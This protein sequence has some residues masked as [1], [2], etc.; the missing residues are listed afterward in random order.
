MLE[1]NT[2]EPSAAEPAAASAAVPVVGVKQP[3]FN[4]SLV[5]PRAEHVASGLLGVADTTVAL[6]HRCIT[7]LYVTQQL[8]IKTPTGCNC[9]IDL[10]QLSPLDTTMTEDV[11]RVD[12]AQ[13]FKDRL[14]EEQEHGQAH[15]HPHDYCRALGAH[16]PRM[17]RGVSMAKDPQTIIGELQDVFHWTWLIRLVIV[18]LTSEPES[19]TNPMHIID[20]EQH[21]ETMFYR[22]VDPRLT[23]R[24]DG[25]WQRM[26]QSIKCAMEEIT[27]EIPPMLKEHVA[28]AKGVYNYEFCAI[29]ST[30]RDKLCRIPGITEVTKEDYCGWLRI[31]GPD[32]VVSDFDAQKK[33]K[34]SAV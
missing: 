29:I 2:P 7:E 31:M 32:R 4:L 14:L 13:E 6:W 24:I 21:P 19:S 15:C 22:R 3:L 12:N 20:S 26:V 27:L 25:Y 16:V 17:Y 1:P 10:C 18:P 9:G 11:K 30:Q 33:S 5:I 34:T 28:Q 23:H 8:S